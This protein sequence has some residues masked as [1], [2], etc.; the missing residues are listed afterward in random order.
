MEL[1]LTGKTAL[2]AGATARADRLLDATAAAQGMSPDALLS[3]LVQ[4]IP[5]GRVGS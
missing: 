2:V 4:T 5:S 1:E 3:Q